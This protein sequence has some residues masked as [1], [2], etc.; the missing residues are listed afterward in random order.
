MADANEKLSEQIS[1]FIKLI[2]SAVPSF[3]YFYDKMLEQDKI[4][5]DILHKLELEDVKYNERA[6]LATE[7]QKVRRD[8]RKY[9]DCVEELELIK[10]FALDDKNKKFINNLGQL[11]GAVRKVEKYHADRHYFPRVVKGVTE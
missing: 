10:N 4:T 3:N 9:K 8:R 2:N 7:L 1:D 11:V 6:R 5:Q